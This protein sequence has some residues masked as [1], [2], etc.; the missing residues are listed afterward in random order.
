MAL[1]AGTVTKNKPAASEK[2]T[3]TSKDV[4][5]ATANIPAADPNLHRLSD[6][7]A[8]VAVLGDPSDPDTVT[9][10]DENGNAVSK[11]VKPRIVGYRVK[12][13]GS[14]PIPAIYAP[15]GEDWS[16]NNRLSHVEEISQKPIAPGE[17]VDLTIFETAALYSIPEINLK[18]S[19]GE[20][21]SIGVLTQS[22]AKSS[23]ESSSKGGANFQVRLTAPNAS[24]RDLDYIEVLTVDVKTV[25]GTQRRSNH[26]IKPEFAEKFSPI[27][28]S[29]GRRNRPSAAGAGRSSA[30]TRSPQ[31]EAFLASLQK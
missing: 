26:Q 13:V 5:E 2:V 9:E 28:T 11:D 21:P 1:K 14:E 30:P 15:I 20:H 8:L 23:T 22:K 4:A 16:R 7:L 31:A 27:A 25:D 10:R 12:N 29:R 6:S 18:A 3:D 19:G 24:I 17:T